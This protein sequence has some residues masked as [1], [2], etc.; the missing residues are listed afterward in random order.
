MPRNEILK[1]RGPEA[2]AEI[3]A[4]GK[5][6]AG[7]RSSL[8]GREAIARRRAGCLLHTQCTLPGAR[9]AR[10]SPDGGQR[11]RGGLVPRRGTQSTGRTRC[12]SPRKFSRGGRRGGGRLGLGSP[13]RRCPRACPHSPLRSPRAVTPGPGRHSGR[14]PEHWN[15]GRPAAAAAAGPGAEAPGGGGKRARRPGRPRAPGALPPAAPRT[16]R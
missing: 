7:G 2:P 6:Q 4:R 3:T 10:R 5:L 14:G 12:I 11:A 16:P 15:K 13:G 1:R 9:R 8:K